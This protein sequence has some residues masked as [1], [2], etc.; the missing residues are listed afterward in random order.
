MWLQGFTDDEPHTVIVIGSSGRRLTLLV[1]APDTAQDQALD[2]LVAASHARLAT[3]VDRG[4]DAGNT[5]SLDEVAARLASK[6]EHTDVRRTQ[7]IERWVHEAAAQFV[8]APVQA[9][10]SI[11][12]EQIVRQQITSNPQWPLPT[13][14]DGAARAGA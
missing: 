12:V 14:A 13:S 4:A 10:V 5:R 8:D 11:L 2:E 9:Y 7:T 3:D 6:E 1:V